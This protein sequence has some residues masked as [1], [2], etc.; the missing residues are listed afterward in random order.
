MQFHPER[1]GVA[2]V[3]TKCE[4]VSQ[5]DMLEPAL[6]RKPCVL[7]Q[8]AFANLTSKLNDSSLFNGYVSFNGMNS[9]ATSVRLFLSPQLGSSRCWQ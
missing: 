2:P 7:P 5:K 8:E 1:N 6:S 3:A 4:I 9:L